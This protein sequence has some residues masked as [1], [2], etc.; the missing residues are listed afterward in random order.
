MSLLGGGTEQL[1]GLAMIP[2]DAAI[3]QMPE[4]FMVPEFMDK[5]GFYKA[6]IAGGDAV[7]SGLL[8]EGINVDAGLRK[9]LEKLIKEK[10]IIGVTKQPKFIMRADLHDILAKQATKRGMAGYMFDTANDAF[11]YAVLAGC[12][13][14]TVNNVAGSSIFQMMSL[15][16]IEGGRT[17]LRDFPVIREI[18]RIFCS[19]SGSI[20]R[21]VICA[22]DSPP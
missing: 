4:G 7:I 8:D 22:I 20:P 19:V 3:G 6:H 9:G 13:S 15:G 10:T 5:L 21:N 18:S 2:W 11:R 17:L 1:G 14:W 12:P 16:A